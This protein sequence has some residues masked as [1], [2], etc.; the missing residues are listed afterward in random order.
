L[1]FSLFV[2][3]APLLVGLFC[4]PA[5]A[6]ARDAVTFEVPVLPESVRYLDLLAAP[7]IAALALENND[8]Y[9]SLSSRLVIKGREAFAIGSGVVRYIGRKADVYSYEAGYDLSLGV[10]ESTLT[11]LVEVDTG[12]AA[13]GMLVIRLHPPLTQFLPEELLQRVEFKIRSLANL[14]SQRKLLTYLDR[15][16]NEEKAK[17]RGFDGMLEAIALEAYNRS[18][19]PERSPSER[20]R[21]EALSDQMVLLAVLAVWLIGFPIFLFLVRRKQKKPA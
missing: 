7:G 5:C 18:A 1:D 6:Q 4:W 15:V 19:D 13:K 3:L 10:G 16:S 20:G 8:L 12:A 9:P 11:F 21:A 2:R 14:Q 17:R